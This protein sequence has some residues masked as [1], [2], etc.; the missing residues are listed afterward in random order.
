M[1]FIIK[2][3]DFSINNFYDICENVKII[4]HMCHE[5]YNF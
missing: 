3:R 4:F 1:D 2:K 5:K